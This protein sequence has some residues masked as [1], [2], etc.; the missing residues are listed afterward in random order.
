MSD[1]P[2]DA[3][4]RAARRMRIAGAALI[5][6]GA[7]GFAL[8]RHVGSSASIAPIVDVVLGAPQRLRPSWRQSP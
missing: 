4:L 3:A 2:A 5:L 8:L 1:L 7:L 6:H